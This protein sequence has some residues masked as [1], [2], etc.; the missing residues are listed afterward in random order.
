MVEQ[1]ENTYPDDLMDTG[2]QTLTGATTK[3]HL[4]TETADKQ[5]LELTI[6]QDDINRFCKDASETPVEIPAADDLRNRTNPLQSTPTGVNPVADDV[7]MTEDTLPEPDAP[8]QTEVQ[9]VHG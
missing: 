1:T 8:Y 2:G 9:G 3:N 4:G 6:P 7:K 5:I